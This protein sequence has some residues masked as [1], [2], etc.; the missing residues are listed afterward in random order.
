MTDLTPIIK[1][2]GHIKSV[3]NTLL[4]ESVMSDDKSKKELFKGYVKS[5]KENEILKTQF[6]V[7]TNIEQKV[8]SDVAKAAMFVKENIELFS[9]FNKKDILEANTK[10]VGNLLFESDVL[11]EK[12]ELYESISTLIFTNKTPETIDH[13]VEAT[14]KIVDYIVNNKTKTVSEAIE[15]P[16]S[17]LSTMMVDKYNEKYAS[18]DES[19]KKILKTLIE[20]TDE[21]KKEVYSNTIKECITLINE[22]LDTSDLNAKDKLLRVKDRLLNDKQEINEDF[23]KNISKLVE[24]RSNLKE[25]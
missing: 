4:A 1:N 22:K 12:K 25:N 23:I 17:M 2:F 10:L 14:S 6:L 18:L 8:E 15:L 24:L 16:N 5:I 9:K 3:Y 20:S 11:D 13:I 7:Y 19:E 21:E